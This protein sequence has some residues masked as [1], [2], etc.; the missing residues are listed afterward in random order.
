MGKKMK[1]HARIF[2]SI[3]LFLLLV[4]SCAPGPEP[5]GEIEVLY[6]ARGP[7]E[8]SQS[9]IPGYELYYPGDMSDGEH[10]IITWGNGT[11]AIPLY[12]REFLDHLASY[13]FVVIASTSVMTGSGQE[14]LQGVD[15]LLDEDSRSGS[16]FF[17]KLDIDHIGATGHSQGGGGTINAGTDPRI[18]CTAPIQP[19]PGRVLEL[20][21][22]TFLIAGSEDKIVPEPW[23]TA[24]SYDPALVPTVYGIAQGA[25]HLTPLMDAGMLRGYLT[26]WFCA[27]LL[28]HEDAS[29][30]FF[31][32][33]PACEI[34]SNPNWIVMRKNL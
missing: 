27:E 11:F 24:S 26:A 13:G 21:G 33:G 12:Y 30:A 18:T 7:F 10:P 28:G 22:P 6:A 1:L 14:M 9:S 15:W 17:N 19:T 3:A 32:D 4:P 31:G 5:V 25:T 16:I 23:V 8:T 2:S 20:Q 34:C 29:E